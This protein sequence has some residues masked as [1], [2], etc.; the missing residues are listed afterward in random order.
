MKRKL[1]L[2]GPMGC[3]KS[4]AIAGA[5]GE[6]LPEFGGFLTRRARNDAGQAIAFYLESPDGKRKEVFL[7]CE[8]ALPR[9]DLKVF[10]KTAPDL[11]KG[12][13]VVLD[14]IGGLEL[15]C[16][17]FMAALDNLLDST[18]P[19]IGVVKAEGPAGA[20]IQKLGLT[21]EYEIAANR[22]R[23]KLRGDPD[24]LVYDCGQYDENALRLAEQWA[25][26]YLH[27]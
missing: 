12:K 23:E 15:L 26:E 8:A 17:A 14:E 2:T 18:I 3:G 10:E 22:F 24:T 13:Y 11:L 27:D 7:N 5:I 6:K 9:I 21:K 25:E 16:P 4:T 1:F 20:M 19:V